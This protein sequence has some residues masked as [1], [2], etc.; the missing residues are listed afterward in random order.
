[1]IAWTGAGVEP[2]SRRK[3]AQTTRTEGPRLTF[4]ARLP[5]L[6]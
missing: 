2:R 4:H 3:T 1:V 5:S 6:F